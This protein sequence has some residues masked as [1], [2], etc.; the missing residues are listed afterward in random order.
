[1]VLTVQETIG[2]V[3]HTLLSDEIP[4]IGAMRILNDAGE[5]LCS[6][7]PWTWLIR[8][9]VTLDFET[10]QDHV[11]LPRDF[12]EILA[13]DV[14]QGLT[15]GLS[16]TTHQYLVEL[17]TSAITTSTWRYW[18]AV[19]HEPRHQQATGTITFTGVP[20]DAS[21]ITIDDG[22]NAAI[23]FEFEGSG[24]VT[25]GN[26]SVAQGSTAATAAANLQTAIAGQFL[27]GP[28]EIEASV[29]GAVVTLTNR[30][31]GTQG[32]ITI[33][34]SGTTNSTLAGMSGGLDG[35]RPEPRL[36]LW[37]TPTADL[38]DAIT[39][40]Y[41]AGWEHLDEDTHLVSVPEWLEGAYLQLVRAHARGYERED[42]RTMADLV[43]E[44]MGGP[45]MVAAIDRDDQMQS[46]FGPL[47][48]GATESMRDGSVPFWNF[49]GV[50]DPA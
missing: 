2:H 47:M 27:T 37:P 12:R 48:G 34:D 22:I 14:T 3:R 44:V 11:W 30:E 26:V 10:D 50:S 29:S 43:A 18:A 31:A 4:A 5:L 16:L 6:L 39:L 17:R 23:T 25:A 8:P 42:V 41:R 36:D 21:T 15:T 40:V 32:N 1:M 45:H 35:G 7:R 46:D 9:R 20:D 13:Y 24:G 38:V 49:T 33:T 19:S 28:F